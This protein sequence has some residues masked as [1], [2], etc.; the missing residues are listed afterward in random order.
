MAVLTSPGNV[1]LIYEHG[2]ADVLRLFALKGVASGD[3]I[4]LAPWFKVV[5]RAVVMGVTQFVEIA[6]SWT[7]TVVTM[8]AGLSADCGY[9]LV[10]GSGN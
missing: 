10:W 7:G 3:T 6:A 4:D 9:L 8:P 5:N 1:Q 2:F